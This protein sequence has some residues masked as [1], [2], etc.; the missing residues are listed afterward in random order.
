M[1]RFVIQ[2]I[3]LS[4]GTSAALAQTDPSGISFVTIAAG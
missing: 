2:A 3:L 4:L 1:P